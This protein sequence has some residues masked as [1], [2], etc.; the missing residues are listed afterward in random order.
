MSEVAR[1]SEIDYLRRLCQHLL[2]LRIF[3]MAVNDRI[4]E[5]PAGDCYIYEGGM[6][7]VNRLREKEAEIVSFYHQHGRRRTG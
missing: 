6:N 5:S 1:L 7:A 3:A 4:Y 2:E